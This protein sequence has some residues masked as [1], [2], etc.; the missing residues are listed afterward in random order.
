VKCR[1]H[2]QTSA[3]EKLLK[4]PRAVFDLSRFG[5][6]FVAS[7][8]HADALLITGPITKNMKVFK[9]WFLMSVLVTVAGVALAHFGVIQDIYDT[10]ISRLSS[11]IAGLYVI[12][13]VLLGY[14]SYRVG[15]HHSLTRNTEH[16][17]Y[18]GWFIAEVMMV[19][20]LAGTVIGFIVL[21]NGNFKDIS[22]TDPDSIKDII[23]AI[24]SGM[25]VALYTTLV[26][27]FGSLLLKMQLVSIE[28]AIDEQTEI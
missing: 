27:I 18:L 13:S 22:F 25:G 20:G 24:A 8:R 14:T 1:A 4:S 19:L 2:F 26:G 11:I 28:V 12:G 21:F 7:P 5:I 15:S 9:R 6:N 16:R 17:L 23:I 10:D 3:I